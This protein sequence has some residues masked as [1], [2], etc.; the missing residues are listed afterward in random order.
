MVDYEATLTVS[1]ITLNGGKTTIPILLAPTRGTEHNWDKQ[2]T[3][4]N[5]PS[6]SEPEPLTWMIDL[7]RL[8]E[9]V[10]IKGFLLDETGY[11]GLLKKRNIR[12]LLQTQLN[13][14]ATLTVSWDSADADQPYTCNIMKA[15]I[16]ESAGSI[17]SLNEDE[18]GDY[19][20]KFY[21]ITIQ[22]VIGNY[23]G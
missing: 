10:T 2:L 22:L 6:K 20:T 5:Q 19:L 23:K 17:G 1:G 9:A 7:K 4:I 14:S 15:Q 16:S 3:I 8:K 21:E 12:K 13:E 11:S 18:N